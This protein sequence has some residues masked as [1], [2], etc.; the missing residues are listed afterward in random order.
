MDVRCAA[1]KKDGK[2]CP[3]RGKHLN[4]QTK[5]HY[6]G[7]HLKMEVVPVIAIRDVEPVR[8]SVTTVELAPWT[9]RGL[10]EPQLKLLDRKVLAK[11]R[12]RL[13][14]GPSS[15][16]D[17]PGCIYVY[18]LEHEAGHNYWKIGMTTRSMEKRQKEWQS[19]HPHHTVVL[20][21]CYDI[22]TKSVKFLERVIHLYLDYRRMYRY[23]ITLGTKHRIVSVWKSTGAGVE[24]AEWTAWN[25]WLVT[26][27]KER[28]SG[29]SKLIEWFNLPWEQI[30]PLIESLVKFYS[31]PL[32]GAL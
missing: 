3:Y 28:L 20:K 31:Q 2:P 10:P 23:P 15:K 30:A 24:D 26:H 25:D 29:R 12:R 16:T 9:K 7:H 21:Q 13:S 17:E 32:T 4:A 11:L 8:T 19:K 1:I 6:C 14:S 27:P 22:P 5:K 18:S